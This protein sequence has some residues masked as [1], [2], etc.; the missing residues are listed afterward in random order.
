MHPSN[1]RWWRGVI[2]LYPQCFAGKIT[3][4]EFGSNDVNGSIRSFIGGGAEEYIGLDWRAGP[5][6]DV[7]SL[8]HEAPFKSGSI[9][10]VVSASMLE[11]D[12]Y[13]A[14]SIVKMIDV[15][16]PRGALFLTWGSATNRPHC[17][18]T[19]PDGKFHP[20]KIGDVLSVL[21]EIGVGV[22]SCVYE[23]GKGVGGDHGRKLGLAAMHVWRD[24]LMVVDPQI[25]DLLPEDR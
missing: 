17:M 24:P 10:T 12:P 4:V 11:H 2:D 5:G 25:D 8:A 9:D 6:V 19:A 14:Q 3:V 22:Q 20:R 18:D 15:L 13:W 16:K 7:V 21:D 23:S 1:E